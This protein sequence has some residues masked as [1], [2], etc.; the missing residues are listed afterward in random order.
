MVAL[1]LG[2]CTAGRAVPRVTTEFSKTTRTFRVCML[3]LESQTYGTGANQ[4]KYWN[5]DP[6]VLPLVNRSPFKPTG[7][8]LS[9]PL[10]PGVLPDDAELFKS[11]QEYA[12]DAKGGGDRT[13]TQNN[14]FLNGKVPGNLLTKDDPTYWAVKLDDKSLDALAEFDLLVLNGHA[15]C[16]LTNGDKYYLRYL[17]ER[18]ATIWVNNSQRQ[19]LQVRNFFIDPAIQFQRGMPS[20]PYYP[21]SSDTRLL[22]VDPT[23]WLLTAHYRLTDAEINLLRDNTSKRSFILSGVSGYVLN[24]I[25]GN[26]QYLLTD[27]AQLAEVVRL[28]PAENGAAGIDTAIGNWR[29][30]A[31]AIAAGRVGRGQLIVAGTDII[32]AIGDWWEFKHHNN[33]LRDLTIWPYSEALHL[34]GTPQPNDHRA[35]VACAKFVFNLLARPASWHMVGGNAAGTRSFEHSLPTALTRGWTVPFT[36]LSE[37]VV[38]GEYTAVTG[39]ANALLQ[40]YPTASPIF[41]HE[42]RVYRMRQARDVSSALLDYPFGTLDEFG[43]LVTPARFGATPPAPFVADVTET[44][45]NDHCFSLWASF[46]PAFVKG[47]WIG[48]PIF[49]KITELLNGRPITRTVLY[50]MSARRTAQGQPF[51]VRLHCYALDPFIWTTPT[52]LAQV[53]QDRWGALPSAQF[54]LD[55]ASIRAS[56]TLSN[57]RLVVTAFGATSAASPARLFLYDATSG[58]LRASIGTTAE[59]NANFRPTAPASLVSAQMEFEASDMEAGS[60][61]SAINTTTYNPITPELRREVVEL[62]VVRGEWLPNIAGGSAEPRSAVFLTPP[63]LVAKL[64]SSISSAR[65]PQ[66]LTLNGQRIGDPA[67]AFRQKQILLIKASGN[68]LKITFRSWDVFFPQGT[69]DPALTLPCTLAFTPDQFTQPRPGQAPT[70]QVTVTGVHLSMGYPITV[71]GTHRY[72]L[73]DRT[74]NGLLRYTLRPTDGDGVFDPQTNTQVTG[75]GDTFGYAVDAPTLIFRDQLVVGTNTEGR[76]GVATIATSITPPTPRALRQGGAVTGLRMKHP[77]LSVP[78]SPSNYV[79]TGEVAWQ[80]FGETKGP[81]SG[82]GGQQHFWRSDFPYPSAV[83][84]ETVFTVGTYHGFGDYFGDSTYVALRPDRVSDL[85][86]T[87]PRATLYAIDPLPSRYL[88]QVAS[89]GTPLDTPPPVEQYPAMRTLLVDQRMLASEL[90][91]MLRVGARVLLSGPGRA[92]DMGR[93]VKIRRYNPTIATDA[94]YWVV[95]DREKPADVTTFAPYVLLAATSVPYLS[96]VRGWNAIS[97]EETVRQSLNGSRVA[98]RLSEG[99][100]AATNEGESAN[101]DPRPG[102]QELFIGLTGLEHTCHTPNS[103]AADKTLVPVDL[104][105]FPPSTWAQLEHYY[106]PRLPLQD[107]T[108]AVTGAPDPNYLVDARLGRIELSPRVAGELADRF[109]VVHYFTQELINGQAQHVRHA[110]IMYVPAIARWQYEF[111]DAVPDSG[112]VLI[113]DTLYVSAVRNLANAGEAPL[114]QP[115]IY[116]FAAV[117]RSVVDV[118]PLWA[119]AVGGTVTNTGLPYRAVTSPTPSAAGLLVG[120]AFPTQAPNPPANELALYLDRGLLVSDG[121]RLLRLNSEG[122]VTWQASATKDHDPKAL[123]LTDATSQTMGVIQQEFV[124]ASRV[125]KLANGHTLVCDTGANRVVELDRD[126]QVAWQYPDSSSSYIDPDR[127]ATGNP[128]RNAAAL[129]ALRVAT[130]RELRLTGP[131]DAR[132]YTREIELAHVYWGGLDLGRATV[133]WESTLIADTGNSRLL[134]VIRPLVNLLDVDQVGQVG[135]NSARVL[136]RGFQYRPDLFYAGPG[137]KKVYLAQFAEV[138]ADG[139]T[140][141]WRKEITEPFKKLAKALAFTSAMRYRGH[142]DTQADTQFDVDPVLSGVRTREV[143]A[144]VSNTVPDPLDLTGFM[145]TLFLR[146]PFPTGNVPDGPTSGYT[147]LSTSVQV[148][149]GAD[150]ATVGAT[151]GIAPGQRVILRGAGDEMAIVKSINR[152]A[153]TVTFTVPVLGAFVT[154]C[155]LVYAEP[156]VLIMPHANTANALRIRG[157]RPADYARLWQLDLVTLRNPT[158]NPVSREVRAL[159]VDQTGVREVPCD[160]ARQEQPIFEMAQPEYAAAL[161]ST[162]PYSGYW[163]EVVPRRFPQLPTVDQELLQTK[164]KAWRSDNYFAPV[165]VVRLDSGSGVTTDAQRARYLISQMNQV[166]RPKFKVGDAQFDTANPDFPWVI[167]RTGRARAERRIH[168][169]EARWRDPLSTTAGW[170]I[171]DTEAKYCI[172]PDPLSAL[173]PNLPGWTYPLQQPISLEREE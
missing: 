29:G 160:P 150:T 65:L 26:L 124:Y 81:R 113:N 116:A 64:P 61:N 153:R 155:S 130:A 17:L 114:W 66:D 4:C 74:T 156:P 146:R 168:L 127:D 92:W 161:A 102:P 137:G 56:M 20:Q 90:S 148:A 38:S 82:N 170:G 42:L 28:T 106:L 108:N 143:L 173:F 57:G 46:D 98:T 16:T 37:P 50:A 97:G 135:Y 85:P 32:G 91:T 140:V 33:G 169:F 100:C 144:G 48:S 36:A 49:G 75:S 119:Q 89:L 44:S 101:P 138:V 163:N 117:P 73:F 52:T 60:R 41:A 84:K 5:P 25:P 40:S 21:S 136:A 80:F 18:G 45:A 1:I 59:W 126:G 94:R 39:Y 70:T 53:A 24:N 103:L 131:R 93:V 154:N 128:L 54:G 147:A 141:A 99:I 34:P 30:Y 6:W 123:A 9:N 77:G 152:T 69:K 8:V 172:Y 55:G 133:R 72:D 165:A 76:S 110:E 171:I 157:G 31:P 166:A 83:N 167:D 23:H 12:G 43:Q 62:L 51:A 109:V 78:G 105:T 111:T 149:A 159:V 63:T 125:R 112:P 104:A 129:A 151:A 107:A 2:G 47:Y 162:G 118:Q 164:L 88:L 158:T 134:E 142:D 87:T 132:R 35:Y 121:M 14:W 67:N 3:L 11:G 122:T 86:P 115:M 22:K 58:A 15:D 7:W 79:T 13:N 145:R 68:M 139:A 95:F 71:R 96:H 10:A 19:G 120:T 27:H